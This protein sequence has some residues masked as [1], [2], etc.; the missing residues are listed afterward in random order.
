MD[1]G[2]L[3]CIDTHC[4]G[5]G[6]LTAY[7]VDNNQTIRVDRHGHL[8]RSPAKAF[9]KKIAKLLALRSTSARAVNKST[10]RGT[11]VNPSPNVDR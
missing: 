4:V 3:V 7:D 11:S 1:A 6:F 8:L 2:H 9:F 10:T 5:T